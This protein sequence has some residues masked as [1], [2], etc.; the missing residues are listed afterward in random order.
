M[1]DASD[2]K[3]WFRDDIARILQGVNAASRI[4]QAESADEHA[5]RAGFVMALVS[6]GLAVG[7]KPEWILMPDDRTAV[8]HLLQPHDSATIS[9]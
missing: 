6:I 7:I 5:Y 4:P 3:P 8:K 9:P 1:R 2:L